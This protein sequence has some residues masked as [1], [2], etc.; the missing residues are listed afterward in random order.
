M[1]IRKEPTM[2]NNILELRHDYNDIYM[3]CSECRDLP[4]VAERRR[5]ASQI[6]KDFNLVFERYAVV[7]LIGK[8]FLKK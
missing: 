5:E 2:T 1:H 8:E 7:E 4:T 6:I 3:R